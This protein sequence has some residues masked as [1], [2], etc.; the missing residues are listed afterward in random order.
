MTRGMALP[1]LVTMGALIF[2]AYCVVDFARTDERQLRTFPRP[3]WIVILLLGSV[4]GAMLWLVAG[5]PRGR[6]RR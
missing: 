5:R 3:V 2:W 1:Y 4:A 6:L